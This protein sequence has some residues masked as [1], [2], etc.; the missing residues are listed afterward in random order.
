MNWAM[1]LT[2]LLVSCPN[3]Y[4]PM[5]HVPKSGH[6]PVQHRELKPGYVLNGKLLNA[7][8]ADWASFHHT[9]L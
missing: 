8:T 1:C 6:L 2:A 9:K 3:K 7:V 5:A 4:M